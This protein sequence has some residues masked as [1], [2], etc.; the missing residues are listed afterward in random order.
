MNN[1]KKNYYMINMQKLLFL[2][3]ELHKRG[4]ENLRVVPC[5]SPNGMAWRCRF[6]ISG[7]KRQSYKEADIRYVKVSNWIRNFDE[8]IE[9]IKL[10]IQEFTNIFEKEHINFLA[11]CKG[12]NREYVEWYK[13]MLNKL[14]E[15]ELP[16]AF[17]DYFHATEFWETSSGNK[18][19]IL[20]SMKIDG[21]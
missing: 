14:Q 7:D 9:E 18:I 10:S 1:E 3:G 12:E 17:S 21:Y 6:D 15:E 5:I 8:E 11:L 13:E 20:P 4:Y 16:Y 2:A 19:S